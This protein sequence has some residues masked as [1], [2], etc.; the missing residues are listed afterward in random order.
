MKRSFLLTMLSSIFILLLNIGTGIITARALGPSGKGILRTLIV[1]PTI[2]SQAAILGANEAYIY[3]KNSYNEIYGLKSSVFFTV[4]I[5]STFFGII[6][7][8]VV[9]NTLHDVNLSLLLILLTILYVPVANLVHTALSIMQEEMSFIMYNIVRV[10]LP[11]VYLSMLFINR[12]NLTPQKCFAYLMT[13]NLFLLILSIKRFSGISISKV[14][15]ETI[16]EIFNFGIKTQLAN[17]MGAFSQQTDQAL[18]SILASPY[19]LGIYSVAASIGKIGFMAPN[20][21]QI[22]LYPT[23]SKNKKTRWKKYLIGLLL[24]NLLILALLWLTIKPLVI[25]LF[26]KDFEP[27]AKLSILLFL[28]AFPIS[29]INIATAYFKATGKPIKTTIA[30]AIILL[31]I[32]F[33]VPLL[34]TYSGLPGVALA[35]VISYTT[36]ATYYGIMLNKE[37][38]NH[39]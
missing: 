36:G 23:L 27:S 9:R 1:W 26:G 18:L 35:M 2:L 22:V 29:L 5:S 8:F 7:F 17:L 24:L 16:R 13:A 38:R 14:K 32:V 20:A 34:Y 39:A 30:Q 19:S 31:F 21:A 25:L 3:L 11:I 12:G 4:L 15:A 33:T 28:S 37:R 6:A 10:T